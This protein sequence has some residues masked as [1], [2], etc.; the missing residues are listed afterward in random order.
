M[1]A[2]ALTHK[3]GGLADSWKEE[4]EK[5]RAMS[6]NDVGADVLDFCARQ[7]LLALQTASADDEELSPAEFGALP[8]IDK[9]PSQIRRWCRSGK[10]PARKV[11]RDYRIRRGVSATFTSNADHTT[12]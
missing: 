12:R 1:V 11:G 4:A 5:R 6:A 7:A 2:V 3:I 8:H 10:I 9:S